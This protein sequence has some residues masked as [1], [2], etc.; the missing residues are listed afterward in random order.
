[1]KRFP[2]TALVAALGFPALAQNNSPAVP[3]PAPPTAPA[4][5]CSKPEHRQFDFWIGDW[6]VFNPKGDTAGTNLIKPML[7]GCVLHENWAG[8]GNF[9]GQS[10]NAYDARRGRWHQTWMDMSGGVL[11]LDGAFENGVMTLTDRDLAGKKDPNVVNEISWTPNPDGS[12]RQHWRTSK[13]GGKTWTTAFDGKYV[14]SSRP[15]P[16]R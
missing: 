5:P 2:I 6:D 7:G 10:F 13:D 4:V 15:Q 1:M 9:S 16:S 3:A 8:K 11:M 12:V 14:R